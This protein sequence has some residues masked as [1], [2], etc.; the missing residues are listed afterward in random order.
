MASVLTPADVRRLEDAC[1]NLRDLLLV[2]L[3]ALYGV[4]RGELIAMEV[5]EPKDLQERR[6]RVP[7]RKREPDYW[8]WVPLDE[9]THDLL[10][11]FIRRSRLGPGR[12]LFRI[13]PTQLTRRITQIADRAGIAPITPPDGARRRQWNVSPHRLRD[14]SVTRRLT[15]P[16][17]RERG[18]EGLKAVAEFHGHKDPRS[19]LRYLRVAEGMREEVFVAGME[20]L[21]VPVEAA[22]TVGAVCNGRCHEPAARRNVRC[23]CPCYSKL[24]HGPG[25]R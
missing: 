11:E 18:L 12:P 22:E 13:S 24:P 1:D 16:K 10:V 2:R 7:V 23:Y 15:D 25:G 14:F 3:C 5:P 8:R 21:L 20:D 4:R 17:L 9:R 19:T 6:L